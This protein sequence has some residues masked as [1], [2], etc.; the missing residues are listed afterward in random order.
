MGMISFFSRADIVA[1]QLSLSILPNN[2]QML[3]PKDT[4]L[5]RQIVN[6][7]IDWYIGLLAGPG[8]YPAIVCFG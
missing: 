6:S 3:Y 1:I 4:G 5:F 2:R 7:A 8:F